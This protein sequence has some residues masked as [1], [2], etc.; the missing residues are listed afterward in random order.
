MVVHD[1]VT[2]QTVSNGNNAAIATASVA[3]LFIADD[4]LYQASTGQTQLSTDDRQALD[5]MLQSS[6]D[7]AG[8][9][10]G[11]AAAGTRS[12]RGWRPATDWRP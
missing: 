6:D 8:E 5:V 2:N 11:N 7:N 4:L 3:K 12:R 10:F 9:L 1:R